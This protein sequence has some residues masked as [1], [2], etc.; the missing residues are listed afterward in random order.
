MSK[1]LWTSD[2]IAAAVGASVVGAPFAASGLDIDTRALAPGDLFIALAGE[3]DGNGFAANAFKAR[4]CGALVSRAVEGGPYIQVDDTLAALERLGVAARDRASARRIAVTGSVGKTSVTQ[5]IFAALRLAGPAHGP[6]KSFNNHIG[7]PLTL[8]RMPSDTRFAVFEIGMNHAGEIGPLSKLVAPHVCVVTTVGPVHTENFPDGE[9]GVARAKAEIFEGLAS[10]GVAILNAD[11]VWFDL[12]AETARAHGAKV[13]SFGRGE[14]CDAQL[15]AFE[16]CSPLHH[17]SRGPPPPV[18]E[19]LSAAA[20]DASPQGKLSAQPTEGARVTAVLHGERLTFP[21]A[22]TG[23]HWGPNSLATLLALEAVG[24]SADMGLQALAAFAPLQGRG[25]AQILETAD[26]AFT[27]IDESYNANPVSMVA[28]LGAL[29]AHPTQ[30]RRIAVLTDML[31]LGA[32]A[33]RHHAGLA[34]PIDAAKVDLVFCAGSMMTALWDVLPQRRRGGYAADAAALAHAVVA[35]IRPGDVVMVK[36]SNGSNAA[37]VV[38]ALIS[39]VAKTFKSQPP[40]ATD[41]E[42]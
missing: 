35:A 20:S 34:A 3:R 16:R 37:A 17:A 19:E 27:L 38:Q 24:V 28:A 22:Q 25:A 30:G 29:G 5:A 4:A 32:D 1:P 21:I 18:G 2:E 33:A 31:E 39:S 40:T 23:A 42:R 7:V 26:G 15:I 6:V 14:G 12:L 41:R 11:D 10:G 13:L 8:S 36:G 9:A